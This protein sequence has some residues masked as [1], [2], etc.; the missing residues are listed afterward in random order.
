MK[1]VPSEKKIKVLT[2]VLRL[3]TNIWFGFDK[4]PIF[5]PA[6]SLPLKSGGRVSA[7][8]G[9]TGTFSAQVEIRSVWPRLR[10]SACPLIRNSPLTQSGRGSITWPT[11]GRLPQFFFCC[12]WLRN[13]FASDWIMWKKTKWDCLA[14]CWLRRSGLSGLS[15]QANAAGTDGPIQQ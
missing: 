5:T 14:A 12:L 2:D 15:Q 9:E 6:F 4:L 11:L 3:R 13:C 7:A 8:A 10:G 1:S